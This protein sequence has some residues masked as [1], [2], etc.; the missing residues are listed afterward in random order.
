MT[1]PK[2]GKR[3]PFEYTADSRY[4]ELGYLENSTISNSNQ[5]PLPL[6]FSHYRLSRTP[7]Y[8][9][10]FFAPLESSRVALR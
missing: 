7:H 8:L 5:F 9:K 3:L 1:G 10:L 4:L 2:G 6:F